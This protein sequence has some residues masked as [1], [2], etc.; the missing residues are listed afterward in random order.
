M[1]Q[2]EFGLP[3]T[4]VQNPVDFVDLYLDCDIMF[5]VYPRFVGNEYPIL[6]E[7]LSPALRARIRQQSVLGAYLKYGLMPIFPESFVQDIMHVIEEIED[8]DCSWAV[9]DESAGV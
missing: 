7:P 2:A 6:I 1:A 8:R 9:I 4:V 5:T 3:L